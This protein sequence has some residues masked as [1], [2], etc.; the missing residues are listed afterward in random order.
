M[1]QWISDGGIMYPANERVSLKN[2]SE[3]MI[4]NPSVEGS[5]F[6][7]E[8][9]EP[10]NDY[11]YEGPCRDAMKH[12]VDQ[13]L[14]PYTGFIGTHFMMSNEMY[15]I[16][17]AKGYDNVEDMIEKTT[18]YNAKDA[19][20]KVEAYRKKFNTRKAPE[21]VKAINPPSGGRNE[22]GTGGD[23]SGGM[24]EPKPIS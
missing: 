12:L 4:I 23:L 14:D 8:E 2:T 15:E 24:G 6:Y 21:R 11:I 3:K 20:E 17:R 13:G 19:K 18:N 16:A 7:K 5:K 1:G 22:A 9:V 10:G